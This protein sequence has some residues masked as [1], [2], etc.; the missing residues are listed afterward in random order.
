MRK[1]MFHGLTGIIWFQLLAISG[2]LLCGLVLLPFCFF[3][4]SHWFCMSIWTVFN[5]S[6]VVWAF[7]P[8]LV[9]A[10]HFYF[11]FFIEFLLSHSSLGSHCSWITVEWSWPSPHVV[12]H[13]RE[14]ALSFN[15]CNSALIC[16]LLPSLVVNE[17]VNK[18]VP[19]ELKW[20]SL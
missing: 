16:S 1:W 7:L 11:I 3:W 13:F 5:L 10:C 6:L 2:H 15:R 4:C 9:T 20:A 12:A 8:R 19:P 18:I 14:S 17:S